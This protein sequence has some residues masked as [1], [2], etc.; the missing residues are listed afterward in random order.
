MNRIEHKVQAAGYTQAQMIAK[1]LMACST[2][3]EQAQEIVKEVCIG[4]IRDWGKR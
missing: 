3:S 4:V 1:W 2:K